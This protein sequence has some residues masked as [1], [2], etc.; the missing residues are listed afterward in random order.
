LVRASDSCAS[1]D[2][3]ARDAIIY[4]D[5]PKKLVKRLS[6]KPQEIHVDSMYESGVQ[7]LLQRGENLAGAPVD[8]SRISKSSYLG[9]D[10]FGDKPLDDTLE[11]EQKALLRTLQDR[12]YAYARVHITRILSTEMLAKVHALED[13]FKRA[14][15]DPMSGHARSA[16]IKVPWESYKR[17]ILMTLPRN[18]GLYELG[19]VL[20]MT[21]EKGESAQVWLHRMDEGRYSTGRA[22]GVGHNLADSCYV[23]LFLR[24]ITGRE[25]SELIKAQVRRDVKDPFYMGANVLVENVDGNCYPASIER[26]HAKY[27]MKV[28]DVKY[29]KP[30]GIEYDVDPARLTIGHNDP[31]ARAMANIRASTWAEIVSKVNGDIGP[32]GRS[33][34]PSNR[35]N[36]RKLY[37]W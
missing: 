28:V 35:P 14:S 21:R 29:A 32:Q 23:E 4:A 2:E 1:G 18:S 6:E 13:L 7:I 5:Q 34:Q 27:G 16:K 11:A 24:G 8:L 19:L 20:A 9:K 25:F 26:I 31:H 17:C 12:C 37:T 10:P 30:W 36:K 3:D 15:R 33:F 22:L